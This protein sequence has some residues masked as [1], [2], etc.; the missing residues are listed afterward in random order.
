VRKLPVVAAMLLLVFCAYA[1]TTSSGY[2]LMLFFRTV[3]SELDGAN[4]LLVYESLLAKLSGASVDVRIVES[5]E[6]PVLGREDPTLPDSSLLTEEAAAAGASVWLAVQAGGSMDAVKLE[7]RLMDV[8]RKERIGDGVLPAADATRGL[9]RRFW[10]DLLG[11]LE[12]A[13][14]GARIQERERLM[15]GESCVLVNGLPG[16]RLLGLP[17]AE[18]P[19]IGEQ[20]WVRVL[21]QQPATYR[22]TARLRGYTPVEESFYLGPEVVEVDLDQQL[23]SKWAFALEL[24]NATYPGIE[25][26]YHV[27]RD[28]L[29]IRFGMSTLMMYNPLVENRTYYLSFLDF[30]VATYLW[31]P[32]KPLRGYLSVGFFNR[33]NHEAT[34]EHDSRFRLDDLSSV[35]LSY[36]LGLDAAL[37]KRFRW[38]VE[39]R[40]RY[41]IVNDPQRIIDAQ[42]GAEDPS[43]YLLWNHHY[44][45]LGRWVFDFSPVL[46]GVQWILR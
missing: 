18:E 45:L 11:V 28:W 41:H 32:V 31:S 24:T 25:A 3:G 5:A 2:D 34:V 27:L 46:M 44:P 39:Y 36:S 13:Y 35:G 16:T 17:V 6:G 10:D 9:D 15:A 38:F 37:G 20:G 19:A 29:F 8:A 22:F 7:Y 43:D 4:G 42:N 26:S 1:Q 23:G 12:E 30:A 40:P 33:I 14:R 21:L